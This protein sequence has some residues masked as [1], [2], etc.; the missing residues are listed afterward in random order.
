MYYIVGADNQP[1]G[2]VDAATL[3]Q[4]IAEG[5]ANGQTQARTETAQSWQ[6]LAYFPEFAP[7]L[8]GVASPQPSGYPGAG[9]PHVGQAPAEGDVT[10][11][12]IPYKNKFALIGYYMAFAGGLIVF[13]PLLGVIFAIG[14]LVMGIKGL[15][16]VKANPVIKGTVHAWIAIIGGGLEII[17]GIIWTI[18]VFMGI[19]S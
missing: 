5:R 16:N 17:G 4:W 12:L 19:F 14:T 13:I 1:R 18:V 6:P 3:N 2:P 15:K 11:G 9:P 7:A 8:T 10:G